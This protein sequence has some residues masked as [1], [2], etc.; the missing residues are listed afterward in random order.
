MGRFALATLVLA[1]A[2]GCAVPVYAQSGDI[3]NTLGT[4]TA[5]FFVKD[6]DGNEMLVIEAKDQS[7]QSPNVIGGHDLNKVTAGA[8]GTTIG[9]GGTASGPNEVTD[10]FGT[11]G[12]GYG[13]T[14][15]DDAGDVDDGEAATVAG[16]WSNTASKFG[17]TVSGGHSNTASD[18]GSSVG[19]GQNNQA[20]A[21]YSTVSGGEENVSALDWACGG[22]RVAQHR[23]RIW[24]HGSGGRR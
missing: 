6:G 8:Y 21:N 7:S 20:S 1:V 5:Q 18:I 22:R 23:L 14:A 24:L 19:G 9:G 13:N 2:F 17:S 10:S 4:N 15:G 3:T 16:G 12:G 11:V